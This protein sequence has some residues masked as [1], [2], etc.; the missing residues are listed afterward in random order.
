MVASAAALNTT[1]PGIYINAVVG[2]AMVNGLAEIQ[3]LIARHELRRYVVVGLGTNGPVSAAQIRQ[4][5]HLIGP[6][7]DLILVNTYGPTPWASS[8]NMVI[9]AAGRHT[10]HVSLADWHAAISGH[11]NLLWPDRIHPRPAGAR[12]YARIVLAAIAA[13]VPHAAAPSCGAA[14]GPR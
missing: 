4:L 1:L 9:D 12:V 3:S 5:R 7:R 13:Q 14:R 6:G 10:A 8:V 11:T 2:R